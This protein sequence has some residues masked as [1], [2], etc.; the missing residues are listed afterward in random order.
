MV[1]YRSL[2]WWAPRTQG[3][4]LDLAPTATKGTVKKSYD[5]GVR[6]SRAMTT[7]CTSLVPS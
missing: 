2:K 4:T 3:R 5:E 6:I 7:R 1:S